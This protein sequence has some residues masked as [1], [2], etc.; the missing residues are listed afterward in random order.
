LPIFLPRI[1]VES[2]QNAVQQAGL[3]LC[4]ITLEPIAVSTL[5]LNQ[6]MRRLNLVLVDIGAGTADIAVCSGDSIN[7]FGMV[8]LAGDE[9]TETISDSYLLDFIK[10]EEVKR[11]LETT[12]EISTVDVMGIDQVLQSD[13]VR[14]TIQPTVDNLAASIAMEIL[15]LNNNKAPQ[16]VLL[17]GGGSLTPGLPQALARMIEVPENRIVVQQAGKLQQVKNLPG[18]FFGPTFITVLGIAYTYLTSPTMGFIN[19]EINGG[20][21]QLL[22]MAQNTVA[23]ALIANGHNLKDIYGRPGLA[24]TCE[25]NGRLCMLPGKPGK[26]GR[27]FLNGIEASF[28]DK[29]K[30]GDSIEFE[31]GLVGEEGSGTFRDI[32]KDTLPVCYINDLEYTIH[33]VI[34]EEDKVLGLDDPV[35]DGSSVKIHTNLTIR[36]VIAGAGLLESQPRIWI[37]NQEIMLYQFASLRKNGQNA[38]VEEIVEAGDQI[39]FILP[40]L[41]IGELLPEEVAETFEVFVNNQKVHLRKNEVFLNGEP[42]DLNTPVK[43]GDK[44]EYILSRKDFCPILIDVFKEVEI[45]AQPPE[46]KTKL[47]LM[48][49]DEEKEYTTEL[50]HG[51]K[52]RVEWI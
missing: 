6:S 43:I 32:L 12:A 3:E 13:E 52:I 44:I 19:L 39:E 15:R 21:V 24:L 47:L 50:K 9:I 1:V 42:A 35:R 45:T 36:E 16:A 11:Q 14:K 48:V 29:V 17:V 10:A 7:A 23:E 33:P 40:E 46:G 31:P 4:S 22:Q 37:N 38:R 49:N 25:V 41:I 51:D 34:M 20:Q 5:V 18:E 30:S 27:V 2:L 26:P 28:S 8:P